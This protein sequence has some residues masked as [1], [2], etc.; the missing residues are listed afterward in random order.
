MVI[1]GLAFSCTEPAKSML[2]KL[3]DSTDAEA[4]AL[5]AHAVDDIRES[6]AFYEELLLKG[7]EKTFVYTEPEPAPKANPSGRSSGSGPTTPQ[8]KR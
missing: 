1:R 5:R 2:L 3:R 7:P 4:V 6:L 8:P